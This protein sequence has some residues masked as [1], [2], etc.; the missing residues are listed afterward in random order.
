MDYVGRI[1]L[2]E[3]AVEPGFVFYR[4]GKVHD[5]HANQEKRVRVMHHDRKTA[6]TA[7]D[8]EH[9]LIDL[10]ILEIHTNQ[11]ALKILSGYH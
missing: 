3:R 8:E 11:E 6:V 7:L 9:A 1:Q 4:L 5:L 2:Q 10:I